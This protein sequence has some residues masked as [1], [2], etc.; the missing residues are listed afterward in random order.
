MGTHLSGSPAEHASEYQVARHELL[1]AIRDAREAMANGH[2]LAAGKHIDEG[3][4]AY[5][6]M[7]ANAYGGEDISEAARLLRELRD[8]DEPFERKCVRTEPL[9]A[10]RE[11]LFR[12]TRPGLAGPWAGAGLA[13]IN[14]WTWTRGTKF[15]TS[16][17]PP[18][19]QGVLRSWGFRRKTVTLRL[20]DEPI[21]ELP[22]LPVN[23]Y[24][25]TAPHER[26]EAVS[27]TRRVRADETEARWAWPNNREGAPPPKLL[28]PEE[29]PWSIVHEVDRWGER[30]CAVFAWK[31]DARYRADKFTISGFAAS[32]LYVYGRTRGN[33]RKWSEDAM[34]RYEQ[35]MGHPVWGAARDEL[36]GY[37]LITVLSNGQVRLTPDGKRVADSLTYQYDPAVW[38]SARDPAL[39]VPPPSGSFGAYRPVEE[40]V[41]G[42]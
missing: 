10:A 20:E 37:G 8:V 33:A 29:G 17:L 11:S 16:R 4:I 34:R 23:P 25:P 27:P 42:G 39:R 15:P 5:G 3:Y 22:P 1:D 6:R 19:V 12:A 31:G 18:E 13:G 14:I 40:R 26:L 7:Q 9:D 32:F 21:S 35:Q 38:T 36:L 41:H 28:P 24:S 2:C 30:I